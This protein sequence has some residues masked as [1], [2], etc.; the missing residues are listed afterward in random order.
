MFYGLPGSRL[1][2]SVRQLGPLI[3]ALAEPHTES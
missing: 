2:S 1:V 3:Y